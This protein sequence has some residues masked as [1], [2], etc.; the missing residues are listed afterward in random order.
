[1]SRAS[2]CGIG[3]D[4]EDQQNLDTPSEYHQLLEHYESDG[5][6]S[7]NN[8]DD[9][10]AFHSDDSIDI[11]SVHEAQ[12]FPGER[13]ASATQRTSDQPTP[14]AAQPDFIDDADD[15]SNLAICRICLDTSSGDTAGGETLGRLLSPCKC[16]G[17]MKYVHA[18]CLDQ[19]RAASARSTSAIACDQCGAPYRFRKSKF[20]GLATSPS[21]LFIVSLFLFLLLIWITGVA[22]T[23]FLDFYDRPAD[24]RA[25]STTRKVNS[26]SW[27]P[28]RASGPNQDSEHGLF[29]TEA[30]AY[31]DGDYATPGLWSYGSLVYEPAAYIKLIKE[32]VRSFATGE[33]VDAVRGVVG[34]Q[35]GVKPEEDLQQEPET[36]QGFWSMLK[37]E[38]LY[39][40]GGLWAQSAASQ[41][42]SAQ[43][44]QSTGRSSSFGS[45]LH[46]ATPKKG[47]RREKYDAR[48]ASDAGDAEALRR[49]R[50]RQAVKAARH[51]P[52]SPSPGPH[53]WVGKLLLQFSV[54]F[55]L[56]GILS[57]VNL[58]VGASF[59]G[60]INLH[61]FGLG[62]S[63]ARMT[64][65]SRGRNGN[66]DGVNIAS[67]LIV[68]LVII[69][70]LRALHVVY[71][72]VRKA[73]RRGLSRLEAVIVDWHHEDGSEQEVRAEGGAL[74]GN[75]NLGGEDE[76]VR[77]RQAFMHGLD[78]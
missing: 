74:A 1:M 8:S 22:A 65:R 41:S 30:W 52:S 66:Q 29:E 45:E 11:E 9:D 19:W 71:K 38:W 69:G 64:S 17:T 31:L 16:K 32:A 49:R 70:V 12:D 78:V 63:F 48:A 43:S 26:R 27:W 6:A 75:A 23:F 57:F 54:G 47:K 15:Q 37:S 67:I 50:Q 35:D 53:G 10:S 20:V 77:L 14:R 25:Q 40:D 46:G 51:S 24:I 60:P 42:L 61:N 33:A 36:T 59:L 3:L 76:G 28:W 72:L 58:L 2:F 13:D 55:S 39:G 62:R 56:V 34:L 18:T 4:A 68:L 5:I 73:A 44:T 7:R 21:L